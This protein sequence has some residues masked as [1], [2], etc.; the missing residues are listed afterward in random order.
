MRILVSGLGV[1]GPAFAALAARSGHELVIIDRDAAPR[2]GGHGVDV[3]GPALEVAGALGILDELRHLDTGIE[4]TVMV[5]RRGRDAAILN[6]GA[7]GNAAGDLEVPRGE[8]ARILLE[9]VPA[10][11]ERRW[12][13]SIADVAEGADGVDVTFDDGAVERFDLV[14]GADG[15]RSHTAAVGLGI[16]RTE[17]A[18]LGAVVATWSLAE[19]VAAPGE[20]RVMALPNRMAMT[21]TPAHGA[22]RGMLILGH[23]DEAPRG[24]GEGAR[25]MAERFADASAELPRRLADSLAAA[26]DAYLDVVA[27]RR[28]PRWTSGRV[29]L[30]GDAAWAPSLLSGQGTPLALVG[31][32]AL[33][34]ELAG[35]SPADAAALA[36]YEARMRPGVERI[37]RLGARISASSYGGPAGVW[38][39]EH[40]LYRSPGLMMR[41]TRLGTAQLTRA[42]ARLGEEALDLGASAAQQPIRR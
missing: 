33:A 7:V 27:Q 14:V 34:G 20:Q 11:V 24:A 1:A 35:R 2:G 23:R 6:E 30:L 39:N 28:L 25:W 31:A 16:P 4:R 26:D 3:R 29:A 17:L 32:A 38:I 42:L 19:P 37:Q 40:L 12:G 10:E 22:P 8:L 13:A 9:S 21:T 18:E 5:D 36:R 41:I 15:T